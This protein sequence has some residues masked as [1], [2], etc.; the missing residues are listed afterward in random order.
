MIKNWMAVILIGVTL[1]STSSAMASPQERAD[2][3]KA[4]LIQRI[5]QDGWQLTNEST[6]L[7]TFEKR[8]NPFDTF[9]MALAFNGSGA[10]DAVYRLTVTVIP[11]TDKLANVQAHLVMNQQNA[12]GRMTTVPITNKRARDWWKGVADSLGFKPVK[13]QSW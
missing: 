10:S 1:A 12:F 8:G 3:V 4:K 7:L 13:G 9:L 6:S 5:T 11:A 2:K